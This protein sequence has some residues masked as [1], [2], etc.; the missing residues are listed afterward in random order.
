MTSEERMDQIHKKFLSREDHVMWDLLIEDLGDNRIKI[1]MKANEA[2]MRGRPVMRV[3]LDRIITPEED[4]HI[5][6]IHA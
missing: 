5:D 2:Y 4:D 6:K 1:Q 3:V